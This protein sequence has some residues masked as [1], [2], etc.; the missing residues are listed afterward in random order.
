MLFY[1]AAMQGPRSRS[2]L[3][4]PPIEL[5][6]VALVLLMSSNVKDLKAVGSNFAACRVYVST[7]IA[8]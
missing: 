6:V 2:F 7:N 8:K 1:D 5:L 3:L 4:N